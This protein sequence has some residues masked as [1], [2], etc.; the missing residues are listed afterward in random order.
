M[1]PHHGANREPPSTLWLGF[2]MYYAKV[3]DYRLQVVCIRQFKPLY[4]LEKMWTDRP[5]AIEDPFDLSHNLGSGVS[6]R[7]KFASLMIETLS[8]IQGYWRIW[9]LSFS[10][11]LHPP[12]IRDC[13]EVFPN[14]CPSS[15]AEFF[16]VGG[17][18]R[19]V[20]NL[21]WILLILKNVSVFL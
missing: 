18:K 9:C 21:P 15:A 12:S 20:V 6:L 5:I 11:C 3:F 10:G 17:L 13:S 2:L 19:N 14:S 4:R 8:L 16:L 7:S 1:W